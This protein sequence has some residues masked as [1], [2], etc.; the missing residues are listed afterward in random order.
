MTDLMETDLHRVIYSKQVLSNNHIKYFIYQ[1]SSFAGAPMFQRHVGP[2][3]ERV[4]SRTLAIWFLAC[5]RFCALLSTAI[6]QE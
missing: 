1:A 5:Y 4:A 2:M 6:P 3:A